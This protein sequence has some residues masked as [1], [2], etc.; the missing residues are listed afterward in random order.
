LGREQRRRRLGEASVPADGSE[1]PE[2]AHV[3][4]HIDSR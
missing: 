4:I 1:G 3:D 2:L